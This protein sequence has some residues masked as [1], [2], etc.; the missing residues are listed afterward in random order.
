MPTAK[1][2][3]NDLKFYQ[4]T[5]HEEYPFL[6]VKT[7]KEIFDHEI[8]KLY[9]LIPSLEDHEIIVGLS[10]IHALFK[11]GHMTVGY[12]SEPFKFHYLPIN[13]YQF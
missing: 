6:F 5:V 3:Q 9:Q 13:L 11:Y 10:R 4:K 1:D 12:N 2:W 7:T 8:E